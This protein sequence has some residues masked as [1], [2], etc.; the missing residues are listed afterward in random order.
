MAAG[1]ILHFPPSVGEHEYDAVSSH[2]GVNMRTG[3]GD[4][5]EGLQSHAAGPTEDGWIVTEI[6]ESKEAQGVFMEGRLGPALHATNQPE[7][8]RVIWFD[9]AAT[10]HRH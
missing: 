7:P 4:W 5:P 2:L 3:E 10:Q 8:A 1:L 6:W 9:I